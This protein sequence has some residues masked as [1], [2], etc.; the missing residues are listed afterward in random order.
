VAVVDVDGLQVGE[1]GGGG[2]GFVAGGR[3]RLVGE[4]GCCW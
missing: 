4:G 2:E 3:G 1:A